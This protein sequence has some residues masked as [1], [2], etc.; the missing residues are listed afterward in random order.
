[1]RLFEQVGPKARSS[2]E[3]IKK[4]CDQIE[5]AK[6]T[7]NYSRV[8]AVAT[9]QFG[10]PRPQTIQ[11]NSELKLYIA[12]R[13]SEYAAHLSKRHRDPR[14][15]NPQ[16]AHPRQPDA[17]PA[18]GLDPKVR[19]CID[20]LRDDNTRLVTENKNLS[21]LLE[22]E[23]KTRPVSLTSAFAL[24]PTEDLSL[25]IEILPQT[26]DMP[27]PLL[28]ALRTVFK[29]EVAALRVERRDNLTCLVACAPSDLRVLLTPAQW[30]S[31]KEW[32]AGLGD[33]N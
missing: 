15:S 26:S 18:E 2:L 3:R 8:A 23:T 21:L 32:I 25:P 22:R 14:R 16:S 12:A 13:M 27:V 24:G 28:S 10:G 5:L 7:M 33:D 6:G 30:E 11:N 31:A 20:L 19:L 29:G 17:Y 4:A 9:E 1:M